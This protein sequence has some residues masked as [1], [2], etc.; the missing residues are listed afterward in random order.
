MRKNKAAA[1][2]WLNKANDHFTFAK[3]GWEECD[4]VSDTCVL[5][6]QAAE[7]A[8]KALLEFLKV[9]PNV[10]PEKFDI[11]KYEAF[12]DAL[13]VEREYQKI[14]KVSKATATRDLTDIVEKEIFEM[15]GVGKREIHYTLCEPKMNQR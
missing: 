15:R 10:D 2:I 8:L 7:K 5:C 4:I 9:S 12:L 11:N 6:Q 14:N 1:E 13:C 3:A